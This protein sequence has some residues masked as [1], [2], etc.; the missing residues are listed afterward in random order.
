MELAERDRF[1]A[2]FHPA[3]SQFC[4]TRPLPAPDGLPDGSDG[5]PDGLL[6]KTTN[7][8]RGPD[9]LTGFLPQVGGCPNLHVKVP[10][11]YGPPPIIHLSITSSS[12]LPAYAHLISATR[13]YERLS[14]AA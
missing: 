12:S 7:V 14:S 9:G 11:R 5:L 8:Y 3:L 13:G 1:D 6:E 4:K 10:N 2:H